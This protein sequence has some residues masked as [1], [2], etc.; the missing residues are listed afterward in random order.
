M[1]GGRSAPSVVRSEGSSAMH[2]RSRALL[3]AVALAALTGL[4][5]CTP[6]ADPVAEPTGSA[7][8]VQPV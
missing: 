2:L 4:T 7:E 5:G 8:G 1:P 3:G 6:S